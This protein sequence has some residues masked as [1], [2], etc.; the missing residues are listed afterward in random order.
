M[1][2]KTTILCLVAVFGAALQAHAHAVWATIENGQVHFALRHNVWG[3]SAERFAAYVEGLTPRT[4]KAALTLS[5]VKN[6]ERTGQLPSGAAMVFSESRRGVD[7]GAENFLAIFHA[8]AAVS[9][10]A[11]AAKAGGQFEIVSRQKGDTLTAEVLWEGA[12]K[13]SIKVSLYWP[14]QEEAFTS[15]TN[16]KGIATFT[17]PKDRRTAGVVGLHAVYYIEQP[18]DFEGKT[19]PKTAHQSTLSFSLK[20]KK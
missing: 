15:T 12:P 6:G 17:L 1:K 20:E 16:E 9:H 14:G 19:Y 8:K 18:V 2:L 7:K 11:A 10:K 5:P 13:A 3:E 4:G